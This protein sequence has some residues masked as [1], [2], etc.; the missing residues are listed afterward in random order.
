MILSY[1]TSNRRMKKVDV[2]RTLKDAIQFLEM[3]P[4]S[5]I[6]EAKLAEELGIS[7]TPIREALLRLADEQLVDIYPQKGTYVSKIDL[8]LAKEMALMRHILETEFCLALCRAKV[9]LADAV[10]E[11]M[12]FMQQAVAKN[13]VYNYIKNDNAF[14]RI[15]FRSAGHE[16]IWDEIVKTRAHYLRLLVL[17]M[18]F[19]DILSE[20]YRQHQDLV[21]S[22]REGNVE[23][24][25]AVLDIHHDQN[26]MQREDL[27]KEQFS[28]YILE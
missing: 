11:N 22:I 19:P 4:G 6:L 21:E 9:D 1:Q 2:Y 16:V 18:A 23:K 27:I 20:S 14:H 7:R 12:F 25:M 24:L 10:A 8:K 5:V 13:D 26:R 17:D 3:K 28:E 15:L